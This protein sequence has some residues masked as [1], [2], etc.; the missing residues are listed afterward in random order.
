MNLQQ[1]LKNVPERI[2][3]STTL[4]LPESPIR[5]HS[6]DNERIKALIQNDNPER[7]NTERCKCGPQ[8]AKLKS[9]LNQANTKIVELLK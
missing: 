9:K 6:R 8:L 3:K 4:C 5:A 2:N 7:W 1:T